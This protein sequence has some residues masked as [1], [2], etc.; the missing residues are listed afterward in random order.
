VRGLVCFQYFAADPSP[1]TNGQ[2]G[3]FR[4][5]ADVVSPVSINSPADGLDLAAAPS[6]A[7]LAS[8]LDELGEDAFQLLS[9]RWVQVDL[10]VA[11]AQ[12]KGAGDNV[13]SR[14]VNIV[15]DSGLSSGGHDNIVRGRQRTRESARCSKGS[16]ANFDQF[17]YREFPIF[18]SASMTPGPEP[19]ALPFQAGRRRQPSARESLGHP[20]RPSYNSLTSSTPAKRDLWYW[21]ESA[22]R[23]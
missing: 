21:I 12:P 4:P 7:D 10:K 9:M 16:G 8:R 17:T 1:F 18:R 3:V 14:S 2:S 19:T 5:L 20:G 23:S 13:I 11:I 22:A 15:D 6:P